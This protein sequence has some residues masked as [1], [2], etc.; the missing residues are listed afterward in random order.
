MPDP[1]DDHWISEAL[2]EAVLGDP[3]EAPASA[4]PP[5]R[6][7]PD[8][9]NADGSTPGTAD[10]P[11]VNPL[12]GRRYRPFEVAAGDVTASPATNP[13]PEPSPEPGVR[14]E[15]VSPGPEPVESEPTG[16]DIGSELRLERRSEP[17]TTIF[18][19]AG[20]PIDDRPPSP[21]ALFPG[22]EASAPPP[23]VPGMPLPA[24]DATRATSQASGSETAPAVVSQAPPPS[25][26]NNDG[27]SPTIPPASLE[28]TVS[29]D[30]PEMPTPDPEPSPSPVAPEPES[31][32]PA[33]PEPV[34]TAEVPAEPVASAGSDP[35]TIGDLGNGEI[36]EIDDQP[37]P[38]RVLAEWI[39]VF[40]G[41]FLVAIILRYFV[42]QSFYIP[43][44][45]ME[46]TLTEND[47][48]LVNKLSYRLHDVNR[49]D[50]IVFRRDP[51]TPGDTD[52]LIKRVIG[53]PGETVEI[54]AG[55]VYIDGLLLDEP[56]L[57]PDVVMDDYPSTP[58]PDDEFFVM[59][60]N[61]DQSF[62][63]R[64]IGTIPRGR[65]VGRAFVLFWPLNRVD[66]L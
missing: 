64:W 34:P 4:T 19:P 6:A 57:D 13:D 50:V 58:V 33:V 49:G 12:G 20:N 3:P 17:T 11:A 43:S 66:A 53:L 10:G 52:D 38:V 39:A 48:V 32:Q 31:A 14:D 42:I 59:G 37:G 24:P 25:T 36:E 15:V 46:S 1:A 40:V 55:A 61:R 8:R 51:N 41:A 45:S 56:Y 9:P 54:R 28:P 35:S 27:V 23:S 65:I 63:S 2:I 62:D 7:A 44:E 29:S 16:F 18:G 21:P 30:E 47:R 5:P 26:P 22:L 60:D